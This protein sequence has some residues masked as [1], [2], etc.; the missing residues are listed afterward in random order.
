ML[1]QVLTVA[2]FETR[3]KVIGWRFPLAV[4]LALAIAAISIATGNS[5]Y[6]EY[7]DAYLA[8]RPLVD[9]FVLVDRKSVV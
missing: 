7:G 6:G 4:A 2:A 5:E 1:S 9:S 3:R 8:M